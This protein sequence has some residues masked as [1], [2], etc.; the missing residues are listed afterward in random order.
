MY[1]KRLYRNKMHA[2][3]LEYFHVVEYETDLL[4]AANTD[5]SFQ[6]RNSV[7]ETRKILEDYGQ[8]YPEFFTALEPLE[9]KRKDPLIIRRMK[10]AAKTVGVGPMA[11]VAGAVSQAVGRALLKKSSEVIVENGGDLFVKTSKK[12]WVAIDAGKSEFKE[13]SI[14]V[15]ASEHPLG[16]CTSSGTMGH[17][18]SFGKADAATVISSDVYLADAA[19]TALGNR[20]KRYEDIEDAIKWAKS[21]NGIR[22]VLIIVENRMGAWGEIELG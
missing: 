6:A 14:V 10:S 13:L 11:A 5:M 2:D 16:I 12:R 20:I 1:E 7:H 22:G 18:L 4:I 17:S 9:I 8:C 21:I 15:K 3:G 19:A